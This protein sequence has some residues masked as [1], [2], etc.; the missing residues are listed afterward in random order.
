[1]GQSEHKIDIDNKT[2]SQYQQTNHMLTACR[3]INVGTA[4]LSQDKLKRWRAFR[5]TFCR[6]AAPNLDLGESVELTR[7][8]TWRNFDTAPI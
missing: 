7:H 8:L 4:V 2:K 6:K 5:S 3:R 1:M